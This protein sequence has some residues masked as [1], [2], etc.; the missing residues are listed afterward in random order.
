[1]INF[2]EEANAAAAEMDEEQKEAL[3]EIKN[4]NVPGLCLADQ[5]ILKQLE[6]IMQKT[7]DKNERNNKMKALGLKLTTEGCKAFVEGCKIAKKIMV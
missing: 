7:F 3:N 2:D 6:T 5:D 4:I 1:M